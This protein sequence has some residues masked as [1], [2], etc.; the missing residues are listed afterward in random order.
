MFLHTNVT[1][2]FEHKDKAILISHDDYLMS[3]LDLI[4]KTPPFI[5]GMTR[6]NIHHL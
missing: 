1:L 4:S 5:I 2:D 6:T 3:V